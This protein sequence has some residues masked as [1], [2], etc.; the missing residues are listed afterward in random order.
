MKDRNIY[1]DSYLRRSQAVRIVG[2]AFIT[3]SIIWLCISLL[4]NEIVTINI[5][6]E[7][8]ADPTPNGPKG[9]TI[10]EYEPNINTYGVVG[11]FLLGLLLSNCKSIIKLYVRIR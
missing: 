10:V 1:P 6:S 7:N 5:Y 3:I 2:L 9:M 8:F 11:S 4:Q